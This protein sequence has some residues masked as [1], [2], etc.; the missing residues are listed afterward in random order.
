[1][2]SRRPPFSRLR[3][4]RPDDVRL[5]DAAE[6]WRS[7]YVH[8]PFCLRRCPYCDFA[9]V[10]E[11]AVGRS[12]VD[13]YVDAVVAEIGMERSFGPLDAIN[14]GGGTPTR[15][16]ARQL[17]SIVDALDHQFG[18]DDSVEVSLEAN[19]E[20]WTQ[21]LAADLVDA[22]FN[23]V[24]IG[25]QSFDDGVLAALG[26]NHDAASIASTVRSARDG[27]FP[28]VSLDLI[29]GHP[30]ESDAS[31]DRSVRSAISLEPNH[32]STYSLTVEP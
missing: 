6:G 15:L 25:A 1:M 27:G 21:E 32:I 12:D 3:D 17:A 20:D 30:S 11:S 13:R 2:S 5:A 9:I 31:W 10:D 24:S 19:P 23:R 18:L 7:A 16:E 14:F 26:R 28:S 4:L 8:I 22:G 29:F